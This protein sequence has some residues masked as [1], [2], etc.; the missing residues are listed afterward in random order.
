MD[1]YFRKKQSGAEKLHMAQVWANW[2]Q[3]MGPVL[4]T[5][6]RPLGC[7]EN[8][9]ILGAEDSVVMQELRFYTQDILERIE[10]F[11]GR[12]PFDKVRLE[13]LNDRTSLDMV[14]L[15]H[16]W[17][18]PGPEHMIFEPETPELELDPSTPVGSCYQAYKKMIKEINFS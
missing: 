13:L 18:V 9:L 14:G 16:T 1:D 6:A 5:L 8:T 11:L 7:R 3:I 10:S 17:Q 12:C 2:A 15:E 4:N